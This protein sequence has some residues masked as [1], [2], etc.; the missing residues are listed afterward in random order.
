MILGEGSNVCKMS[1]ISAENLLNHSSYSRNDTWDLE[2]AE[3]TDNT[4]AGLNA[5]ET[6]YIQ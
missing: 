3:T 5:N 1:Y 2:A 6:Q 4:N